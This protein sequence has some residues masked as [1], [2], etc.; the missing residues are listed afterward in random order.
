MFNICPDFDC[1][2]CAK[3]SP[4]TTAESNLFSLLS[5]VT[6]PFFNKHPTYRNK[7]IVVEGG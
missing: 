6:T 3:I 7:R 1:Q 2:V 4:I 5:S